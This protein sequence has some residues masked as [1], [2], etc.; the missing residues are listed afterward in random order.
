MNYSRSIGTSCDDEQRGCDVVDCV[1]RGYNADA[2][3]WHPSPFVEGPKVR[4]MT[5]DRKNFVPL[6]ALA[7]L[8][9]QEKLLVV[10][11]AVNRKLFIVHYSF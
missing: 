7:T 8:R 1:V 11:M 6:R 9:P 10:S 3:S 5:V 4:P 2:T